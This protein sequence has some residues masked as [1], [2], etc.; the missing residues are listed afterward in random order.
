MSK[1]EKTTP[2]SPLAKGEDIVGFW[3]PSSGEGWIR[4]KPYGGFVG[5]MTVGSPLGL[6][7]RTLAFL[8]R[9]AASYS[10]R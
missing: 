8:T 2:V 1:T 3:I 5:M 10:S 7:L 9:M 4:R 6:N